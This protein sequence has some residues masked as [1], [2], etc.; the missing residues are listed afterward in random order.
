MAGASALSTPQD[1]LHMPI[2]P[3]QSSERSTSRFYYG[4]V[5]VVAAFFAKLLMLG[6]NYCFGIFFKPLL[7]EFGWSR[8]ITSGAFSLAIIMEGLGS[9]LMGRMADRYSI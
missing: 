8:A 7:T 4:Y 6:S 2:N 3:A 1:K 5:I 9:M